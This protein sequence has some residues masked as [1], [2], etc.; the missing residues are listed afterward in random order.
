V[1]ESTFGRC[2]RLEAGAGG[3]EPRRGERIFHF[4]K[5][6]V[7]AIGFKQFKLAIAL[8]ALAAN[9]LTAS[10]IWVWN[11]HDAGNHSLRA[12]ITEA[13]AAGGGEIG[14]CVTGTITLASPLPSLTNI[15]I[16]GPGTNWLTISGDNQVRVFSMDSGTTNT[17]SGLTI[18][19]GWAEGYYDPFDWLWGYASG[20]SNAGSLKLLN[21]TVRNCEG[22]QTYGAGVCNAGD[23]EMEACVI[24][25]CGGNHALGGGIYS[26]GTLRMANCWI[27]A[28]WNGY[29][30][31]GD[32]GGGILNDG[33]L[34]MSAS[35]VE[36]C[37]AFDGDGGGICN[38]GT[39]RLWSCSVS[40]CR[41]WSGG[42]ID[43]GAHLAITN[44]T[45]V[46][47]A[48]NAM[49]GGLIVSGTAWLDGC[50]IAENLV[51]VTSGG[52]FNDGGELRMLNCT[53]S[54]NSARIGGGIGQGGTI[55]SSENTNSTTYANYCT[56]ASNTSSPYYD[57]REGGGVWNGAGVFYCQ[58]SIIAGNATNDFLGVL[59]SQGYNLIQNTNDCT[60]TN[61]QTGNIYGTDPLLGPLQDNG[62]PTW[63][64]ALLPG[65]PAIDAGSSVDTL[66]VD[67]R[68]IH[69]PQGLAPDI[70]AFE[71]QYATPML[72]R[73]AVESC[74]NCC[75]ILC[76]LS[77]GSYT[78][79][80]S[81]NLVNWFDVATNIA[82]TNGVCEFTERGAG[83]CSR[84]FYRPQ[85]PGY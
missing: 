69:R 19:N 57:E 77:G 78:L 74:T 46:H 1:E 24:A 36:S 18:A 76:G 81:T 3:L 7:K 75:L 23:M 50:T 80:A 15:T 8:C 11:T 14:F 5:R 25:D 45:I 64:H 53:V 85:A 17:L 22:F 55:Y 62:G 28:C 54:G 79:Q 12:A 83:R 61:D 60:I 71:F 34:T 16:T 56:I 4:Q 31:G 32:G 43:S 20:I 73:M 49:G 6:L 21:C 41:G 84:R 33:D 10:P 13:N 44:S 72:A 30:L 9:A 63:T 70:G 51:N 39:A 68:G 48:A 82:D 47:N 65:S 29:L 27:S 58:N 26:S 38:R 40:N 67:Q 66:T 2:N 59:I 42:G 37:L 52:I 35:V